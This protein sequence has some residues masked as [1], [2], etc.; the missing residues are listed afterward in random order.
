MNW[1]HVYFEHPKCSTGT[2]GTKRR[3]ISVSTTSEARTPSQAPNIFSQ[4]EYSGL[5][6]LDS[7]SSKTPM[8]CLRFLL[9]FFAKGS[10]WDPTPQMQCGEYLPIRTCLN[11]PTNY[12]KKLIH[13]DLLKGLSHTWSDSSF[14]SLNKWGS[15]KLLIAIWNAF[16][17][18]R[19]KNACVS[20]LLAVGDI[21]AILLTTFLHMAIVEGHSLDLR[22]PVTF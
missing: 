1:G 20:F 14:R 21:A 18:A 17:R 2:Q 4:L 8:V 11:R 6:I 13:F 12:C 19:S 5:L 22:D 7:S 3:H 9:T 16:S 15:H 10:R